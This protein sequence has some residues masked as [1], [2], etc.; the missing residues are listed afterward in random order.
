MGCHPILY[1]VMNGI[2]YSA[3]SLGEGWERLP[4]GISVESFVL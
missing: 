2:R 3:P 1:P 4:F